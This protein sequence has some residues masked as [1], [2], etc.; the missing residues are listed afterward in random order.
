MSISHILGMLSRSIFQIAVLIKAQVLWMIVFTV[1]FDLANF[2]V[3]VGK[4]KWAI[5]QDSTA[6]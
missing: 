2:Y 3:K 6:A 4:L 1:K 5:R